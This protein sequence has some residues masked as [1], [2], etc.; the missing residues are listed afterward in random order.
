MY[1]DRYQVVKQFT[2]DAVETMILLHIK[3]TA[4][5]CVLMN[6]F[7]YG[8]NLY[9]DTYF[10]VSRY[11]IQVAVST[12]GDTSLTAFKTGHVTPICARRGLARQL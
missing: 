1:I 8:T 5:S 6:R 12:R 9:S 4:P 2:T 7:Q 3:S 10:S 11:Q